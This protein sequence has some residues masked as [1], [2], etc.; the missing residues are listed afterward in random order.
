LEE[1][2]WARFQQLLDHRDNYLV[3][4][5]RLPPGDATP[6]HRDL[7]HRVTVVLGEDLLDIEYKDGGETNRETITSGEVHWL[8]P[9]DRAHRAVNVGQQTFEEITTFLLDRPA[10][11]P[12]PIDSSQ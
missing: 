5:L 12:Q 4:R 1:E 3:R 9:T 11:D 10:A 7:F 2:T 6:W 8:E